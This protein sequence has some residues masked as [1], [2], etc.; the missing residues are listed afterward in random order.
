[1][2]GLSV[3]NNQ[4]LYFGKKELSIL[5]LSIVLLGNG[6]TVGFGLFLITWVI[7]RVIN[8]YFRKENSKNLST[9]FVN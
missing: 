7:F 9:N 3:K 6:I 1:M 4:E 8:R 5:F 2:V